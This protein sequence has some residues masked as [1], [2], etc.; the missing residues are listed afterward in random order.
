[1][2]VKIVKLALFDVGQHLVGL[3]KGLK[4]LL[5]GLVARILIGMVFQGQPA[6]GSLDLL[7]RSAAG[8]AQ[9]LVIIFHPRKTAPQLSPCR[10]LLPFYLSLI[11]IIGGKLVKLKALS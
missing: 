3:G 8:D 4:L 11:F 5:R 6:V 9:S 10:N 1:V 7:R 2:P